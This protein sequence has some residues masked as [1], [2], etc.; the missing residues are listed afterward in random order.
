[1]NTV[2]SKRSL[3][4]P[5]LSRLPSGTPGREEILAAHAA[6]LEA[7]APS[8]RDPSS[9]LVVTSAS[10]LIEHG[11]CCSNGCRHCPYIEDEELEPMSP[12][13]RR[14]APASD[15]GGAFRTGLG[16]WRTDVAPV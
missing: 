13:A 1:M 2:R 3:T 16:R 9:G 7:G 6:A 12:V 15:D 14:P 5:A 11:Y 10:Y 4:E 8:Y